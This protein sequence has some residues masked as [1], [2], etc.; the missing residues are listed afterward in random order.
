E[1]VTIEENDENNQPIQSTIRVPS[2]P[3]FPVQKCLHHVHEL[4]ND[5]IPQTIPRPTILLIVERL[6]E[7]LLTHYTALADD[8]F[9]NQNQTVALQFYLDMRFLQLMLI[10][11]EQKQLS[12]SFNELIGRFKSYIDPFDFDVFYAHLNANVKRSVLKLQHF[13]GALICHSEQLATIVGNE[14][15]A[16]TA[17]SATAMVDKNPNI[18]ALSCNSLNMVWFPL[19]PVVS[20]EAT[21]STAV[22][23]T[24]G[25]S[26][27]LQRNDSFTTKDSRKSTTGDGEMGKSALNSGTSKQSNTKESTPTATAQNYAKGAAAFFGLDKDW[28][29]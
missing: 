5:A 14:A 20:K 11:R 24:V 6:A 2:Q 25:L 10:G 18:L 15:G 29:R 28:F 17:S 16:D 22:D 13:L 12:E 7:L 9:V 26:S 27:S 19:L 4:L 21:A 8:S 23:T 1:I 3:S